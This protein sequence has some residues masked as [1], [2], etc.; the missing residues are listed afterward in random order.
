MYSLRSSKVCCPGVPVPILQSSISTTGIIKVVEE[1]E[2]A[3]FAFFVSSMVNGFSSIL[4]LAFFAYSN[5]DFLVIPGRI[6]V[7]KDLVISVPLL[8]MMKVLLMIF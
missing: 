1:Q 3:S 6:F 2:K 4:K 8:D 5:I 7:D